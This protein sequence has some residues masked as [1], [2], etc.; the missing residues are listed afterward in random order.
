[1]RSRRRTEIDPRKIRVDRLPDG[2]VKLT[3]EN[4]IARVYSQEDLADMVIAQLEQAERWPEAV[5]DRWYE[6]LRKM[7]TE[8]EWNQA[9]AVYAAMT[10]P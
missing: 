1:M 3:M 2:S 4:G 9:V 5:D 6:L 7:V 8:E 10:T